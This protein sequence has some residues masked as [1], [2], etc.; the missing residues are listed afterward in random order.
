MES[1]LARS[2]P[3]AA[4]IVAAIASLLLP[5][6]AGAP[7]SASN[8]VHGP[9][10]VLTRLGHATTASTNW[11]GYGTYGNGTTFTSVKGK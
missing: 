7:A 8:L 5:A 6:A 1:I 9:A 4:V 11:S 10:R 3:R 2:F